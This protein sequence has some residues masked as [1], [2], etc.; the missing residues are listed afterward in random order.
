MPAASAVTPASPAETT[1]ALAAALNQ[2]E[3]AAAA[4]C[5]ALDACLLTPDATMIRGREEIRGILHQLILS[6]FRLEVSDSVV[7]AAGGVALVS[8]QWTITSPGPGGPFDQTL[9][10]KLVVRR[11]EE[12]WKLAIAAPW[13]RL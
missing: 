10:P 5:F 11:V 4:N 2:G 13:S 12:T 8:E 3:L 6:G 7:L 1:A 9:R